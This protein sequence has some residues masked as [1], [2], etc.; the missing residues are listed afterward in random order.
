VYVCCYCYWR[1]R[2]ERGRGS[3]FGCNY[4]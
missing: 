3:L 2:R 1:G 4:D